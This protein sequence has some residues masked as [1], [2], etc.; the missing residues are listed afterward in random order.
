V[1]YVSQ[2]RLADAEQ[3]LQRAL[4]IMPAHVKARYNLG[5]VYDQQGKNSAEQVYSETLEHD[6]SYPEPRINLGILLTKQ[7]RYDEALTQLRTAQRYAPDHPVLLYALGD[8]NMK[9]NRYEEAISIF[10]Q[11]DSRGLLQNIVHTSLGLCYE[12]L[13]KR[14]EAKIEFQKSVDIAPQDTYTR[15]AREHLAKLQAGA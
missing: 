4:E 7:R 12:N 5:W 10:K 3:P 11:V 14:D 13:G 6:P 1:T 9:T 8:I 2:S 15:T